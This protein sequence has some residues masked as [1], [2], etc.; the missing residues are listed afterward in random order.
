MCSGELHDAK[1]PIW[2]H[3]GVN[4]AGLRAAAGRGP[5][6]DPVWR[7]RA[8]RARR[9]RP[10]P[11]GLAQPQEPLKAIERNLVTFG[12]ARMRGDRR[13]RQPPCPPQTFSQRHREN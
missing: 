12:A 7:E 3:S 13:R 10:A 6:L 11:P 5:G 8:E 4:A 1:T 9:R 2:T